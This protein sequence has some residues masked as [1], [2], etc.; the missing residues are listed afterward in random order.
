MRHGSAQPAVDDAGGDGRLDQVARVSGTRNEHQL[1][2]GEC[3]DHLAPQVSK[4]LIRVAGQDQGRHGQLAESSPGGD[5]CARTSAAKAVGQARSGV[6]ETGRSLR[7]LSAEVGE[8]VLVEPSLEEGRHVGLRN[9][10]VGQRLVSGATF[11]SGSGIFD[12]RGGAD[13]HQASHSSG[14][15]KRRGHGNAATERVAEQIEVSVSDRLEDEVGSLLKIGRYVRRA[16]MPR[17]VDCHDGAR[18]AEDRAE[19][20]PGVRRLGEPVEQDQQ[21]TVAPGASG[22][23]R[24]VR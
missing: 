19:G 22:E 4:L 1:S 7:V 11:G 3:I 17:Q 8:E 16:A 18:S 23:R 6:R 13:E 24:H 2:L 12:A 5:L 15:R 21:G 10:L 14:C 9:D 20:T